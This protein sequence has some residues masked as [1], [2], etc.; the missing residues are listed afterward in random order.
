MKY[1]ISL[2]AVLWVM[3]QAGAVAQSRE[4][5]EVSFAYT[6]QP[7]SG[8]NQ[9]ALWIEDAQGR[10]IKTLY[11]TRFTAQGGLERRPQ[12]IPQWVKQ[13]GLKGMSRSQI[14]SFTGATPQAGSLS[15]R[16]DGTDQ[17][18]AAVPSGEYHLYVEATFR[19]ENRVVY[20]AVVQL[21]GNPQETQ[22]EAQ[23]FGKDTAGRTMIG[24]VTVRYQ[25]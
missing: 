17:G 11:A 5:V 10:Y 23:Y 1:S 7:G 19:N 3:V 22:A 18:G 12:S 16:W 2:L 24:P 13:S 14:D 9:F 20:Q 15:Y 4:L 21:G 8:S 6:R 25:R